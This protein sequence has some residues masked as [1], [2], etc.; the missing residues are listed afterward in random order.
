MKRDFRLVMA[1]D[2]KKEESLQSVTVRGQ[3][4][5]AA[6]DVTPSRDDDALQQ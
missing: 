4:L 1:E 6:I 2:K 5:I 3:S